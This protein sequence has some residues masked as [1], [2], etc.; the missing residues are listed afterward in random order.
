MAALMVWIGL[1][2]FTGYDLLSMLFTE[3]M[4]P[5]AEFD[6]NEV[7]TIEW[8]DQGTPLILAMVVDSSSEA[9][10]TMDVHVRR[11]D[12]GAA[13]TRESAAGRRFSDVRFCTFR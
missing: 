4:S 12:G 10:P 1:F 3:A 7:R 8:D 2:T 9:L 11:V 5:V 13:T 6:E